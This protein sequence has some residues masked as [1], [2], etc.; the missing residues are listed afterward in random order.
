MNVLPH[1]YTSH[2]IQQNSYLSV[3]YYTVVI[4][5]SKTEGALCCCA[6]E[7]PQQKRATMSRSCLKLSFCIV[8]LIWVRCH[9][10]P[11]ALWNEKRWACPRMG[12]PTPSHIHLP[13]LFTSLT[14][15]AMRRQRTAQA[16]C[17]HTPVCG[18]WVYCG[19]TLRCFSFCLP[20]FAI[21][22]MYR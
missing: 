7:K 14:L 17:Q 22:Y 6:P 2:N 1:G 21:Q 20:I 18:H 16:Q 13:S 10:L 11:S 3:L 12:N 19:A 4:Q 8:F 5:F 9:F 15:L